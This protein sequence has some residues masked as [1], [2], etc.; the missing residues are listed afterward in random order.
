MNEAMRAAV[1]AVVD[2]APP[3]TPDKAAQLRVI[4]GIDRATGPTSIDHGYP[5]V[6]FIL[7]G[8]RIKIGYSQDPRKRLLD[9]QVGSPVELTLLHVISCPTRSHQRL[10]ERQLHEKFAALR[11]HGEWFR[12]AGIQAYVRSLCQES[13]S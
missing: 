12:A 5:G 2:R 8:D 7:A 11:V 1:N 13:C 3:L 9:M 4:F 6:Y 10:V